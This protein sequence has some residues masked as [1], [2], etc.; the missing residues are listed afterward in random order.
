MRTLRAEAALV[1]NE[2]CTLL[3]L[4]LRARAPE[5][6]ELLRDTNDPASWA[7]TECG[8]DDS[9]FIARAIAVHDWWAAHP[10]HR[11][12]V[13]LIPLIVHS[14][15]YGCTDES[16]AEAEWRA[17][18]AKFFRLPDHGRPTDWLRNGWAANARRVLDDLDKLVRTPQRP[19][20]S[21]KTDR[22][23]EL[24]V[25]RHVLGHR[26]RDLSKNKALSAN[27]FSSVTNDVAR[28]LGVQLKPVPSRLG[29]KDKRP[30]Q[31][32]KDTL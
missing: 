16:P 27:R 12:T 19:G 20:R 18:A 23:F 17:R 7:R 6:L 13:R 9:V 24:F 15:M 21:S 29:A 8:I 11:T 32:R 28:Q 2:D 31:V 22:D 3:F 5:K 4:A 1:T 26:H 14:P 25:E 10:H 30:R